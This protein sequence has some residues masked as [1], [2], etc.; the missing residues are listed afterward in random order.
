[1]WTYNPSSSHPFC[2][3]SMSQDGKG[4]PVAPFC[5]ISAVTLWAENVIFI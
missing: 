2:F 4:F 1:M 5:L 3:W